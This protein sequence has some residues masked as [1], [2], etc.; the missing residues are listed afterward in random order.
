MFANTQCTAAKYELTSEQ[1]SDAAAS[2]SM[3]ALLAI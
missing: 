3:I 2:K 1:L